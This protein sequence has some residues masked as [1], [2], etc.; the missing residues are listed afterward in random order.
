MREHCIVAMCANEE[1][2]P[3][4]REDFSDLLKY[5]PFDLDR[6]PALRHFKLK[7]P[8]ALGYILSV[9]SYLSRLFSIPSSTSCLET[10]ELLIH[11]WCHVEEEDAILEEPFSS[12]AEWDTLD[13]VLAEK[14]VSLGKFVLGWNLQVYFVLD[15]DHREVTDDFRSSSLAEYQILGLSYVNDLFPKLR[16]GQCTLETQFTV[17]SSYS[18]H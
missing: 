7:L 18:L 3:D 11:S 1:I 6:L 15:R 10:L 13:E 4:S 9:P 17:S 2:V 5:F 16:R 14:F 8:T 12:N